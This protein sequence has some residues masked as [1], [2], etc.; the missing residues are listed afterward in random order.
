[1]SLVLGCSHLPVLLCPKT[2]DRLIQMLQIIQWFLIIS[3]G[4]GHLAFPACWALIVSWLDGAV[5]TQF[6]NQ[7]SSQRSASVVRTFYA[8]TEWKDVSTDQVLRLID[9][10]YW[11]LA[12]LK[13]K[14]ALNK[15]RNTSPTV[16]QGRLS[17]SR[18]RDSPCW[19]PAH[20]GRVMRRDANKYA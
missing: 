13:S 15:G 16:K 7:F 19:H 5:K 6:R 18:Q 1:M 8:Q 4:R 17:A 12:Q 20:T 3:S 11:L 9:S 14:T 10:L 2:Y